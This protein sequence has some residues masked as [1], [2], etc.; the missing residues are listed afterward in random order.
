MREEV[1][2]LFA[3][4]ERRHW[5]FTARRTILEAVVHELVPPDGT[6]S[7]IDVGC[8]TGA[9]IASFA[10]DYRCIGLDTAPAAIDLARREYPRVEFICG[11]APEALGERARHGDLFLLTDVLEHIAADRAML[12]S[13][14]QAARCGARFL[15]TVPADMA[16][17]SRHD[18]DV[19]HYRRYEA[20]SLRKLWRD[21][22]LREIAL[23]YF[24]A[25]LYP[26]VRLV[27][28]LNRR[29]AGGA[30]NVEFSMPPAPLN[31]LLARV[32]VGER[33]RVLRSLRG[34]GGYGRGVSLLA[35]LERV[36]DGAGGGGNR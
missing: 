11:E 31:R 14:A 7:I 30:T 29:R 13:L 28:R 33:E 16:L 27:R 8:G 4:I 10:D 1:H 6:R 21:L 9:N 26:A 32:F 2:R 3:D 24:N 25:R 5:W 20:E 23:T 19:S 22:P 35:A 12:G 17:W 18:E 36:G 15:I 34:A